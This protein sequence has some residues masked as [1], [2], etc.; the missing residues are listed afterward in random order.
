MRR[1]G[2][3]VAAWRRPERIPKRSRLETSHN[4]ARNVYD[5]V[6]ISSMR[7]FASAGSRDARV[8]KKNPPRSAPPGPHLVFHWHRLPFFGSCGEKVTSNVLF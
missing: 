1:G 5:R 3:N 8:L 6:I 4:A 2:V 7:G